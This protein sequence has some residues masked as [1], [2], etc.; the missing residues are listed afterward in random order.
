MASWGFN[1]NTRGSAVVGLA[2]RLSVVHQVNGGVGGSFNGRGA[3]AVGWS[4]SSAGYGLVG[5]TAGSAATG[6]VGAGNNRPMYLIP[7]GSGGAFTG[8]QY[9]IYAIAETSDGTRAGGV[10]SY[11][12]GG[13]VA[14]AL[15]DNGTLYKIN[16]PGTVNTVMNT[17]EGKKSLFCPEMPEAYFEDVGAG[18]LVRGHCRI[19]L[20]PLFTD[21]IVTSDNCPL[22]VFVQLEDDCNGV[23]V[24]TD[25]RGFDVYELRQGISDAHFSYRV[26]GKWKGYENLRF[27]DAPKLPEGGAR[28]R[29]SNPDRWTQYP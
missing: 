16:G 17:R 14:V 4:D 7:G 25:A 9:G 28:L 12:G 23:Y 5:L 29:R 1:Y 13:N 2:N 11:N 6:V 21:C 18:Q 8:R 27:P 19:E 20:A 15:N 10:F 24:R 26:L 22:K 3:G